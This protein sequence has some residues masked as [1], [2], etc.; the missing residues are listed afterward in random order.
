MCSKKVQVGRKLGKR[1]YL[2]YGR[3]ELVESEKEK[4]I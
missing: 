2:M 4:L 1:F 3:R